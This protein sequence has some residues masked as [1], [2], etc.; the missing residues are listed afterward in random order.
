MTTA[1]MFAGSLRQ[2]KLTA[3]HWEWQRIGFD[4]W[5]IDGNEEVVQFVY[6]IN[7]LHG[8]PVGTRLYLGDGAIEHRD[9]VQ[10]REYIDDGRVIVV[11][12]SLRP[13]SSSAQVAT[14][15]DAG[16]GGIR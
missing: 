2:A 10:L 3:E 16:A 8:K 6:G 12:G 4:C 5:Q 13:L 15:D 14:E 9:C 1:F 7:G 11:G